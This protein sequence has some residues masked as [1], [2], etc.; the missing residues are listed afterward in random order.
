MSALANDRSG[1]HVTRGDEAQLFSAYAQRLQREVRR[2]VRTTPEN[3]EDACAFAFLQLLRFQPDRAGAYTWLTT[4]A[5]REA[6]KLDRRG[7]RT[8]PLEYD[9]G[10]DE[11]MLEPP[12]PTDTVGLRLEV[13]AARQAID[14]AAL[15]SRQRRLLALQ[16]LGLSYDE[17]AAQTGDTLRTIE[18]QLEQART[19]LRKALH[20]GQA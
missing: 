19:K 11:W 5:V 16:V 2:V 17:I 10:Y 6:I 7:R 9:G 13:L 15:S 1:P 14:A 12:A 3:V 18:R 4:T 8:M 20:A